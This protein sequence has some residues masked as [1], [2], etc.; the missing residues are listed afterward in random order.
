[1]DFAALIPQ[2]CIIEK[3]KGRDKL[4][5]FEEMV[6]HLSAQG[7]IPP[8][9]V[10]DALAGILEREAQMTTAI[11]YGICLPHV[12]VRGMKGLAAALGRCATPMVC[13]SLDSQPVR[14]FILLIYE[15]GKATEHLQNLAAIAKFFN[16]PGV[17]DKIMAARGAAEIY[18]VL[19][20]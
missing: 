15:E 7:A 17:L 11:G 2:G 14:L 16:R 20:S 10:T 8:G 1:M 18:E 6:T 12:G 19:K 13:D 5:V 3:L 9:K 4:S